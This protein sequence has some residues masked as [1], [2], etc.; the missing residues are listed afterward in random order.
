MNSFLR[1]LIAVVP[2][3]LIWIYFK[4]MLWGSTKSRNIIGFLLGL[5]WAITFGA[6]CGFT[7]FL[8]D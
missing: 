4:G 1:T 6:F 8:K 7:G 5:V 3:F 2:M